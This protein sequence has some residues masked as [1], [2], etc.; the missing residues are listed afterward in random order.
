MKKI[1]V[2]PARLAS[3]RLPNKVL[4]D[5][6]GKTI[7][8]RVYEQCIKVKEAAVFIATDSLEVKKSCSDYTQNV[9][10]TSVEHKSGTDRITEAI[11]ELDFEAIVNVQGDEPFINPSLIQDLFGEL[12]AE[13]VKVVTACE[14]LK[15]SEELFDSNVVKVVKDCENNALYFSRS[16]IPYIRDDSQFLI[17]EKKFFNSAVFYKHVGIYGYK[18]DFLLKYSSSKSSNLE[19]LEMLEQLRFLESGVRIKILETKYQSFGIDTEEDYL[20]ALK[21]LEHDI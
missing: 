13:K 17:D 3:T 14:R 8:Q 21:M 10:M 4:L 1:I 18:K 20:K 19:N 16:S 12:E 7:L 2:I 9:I 15:T 5:L 11:K 6:K